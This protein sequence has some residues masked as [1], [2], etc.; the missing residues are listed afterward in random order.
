MRGREGD[1]PDTA[2]RAKMRDNTSETGDRGAAVGGGDLKPDNAT[3]C[4]LSDGTSRPMAD[5]LR[6][7]RRDGRGA[8]GLHVLVADRA[9][10]DRDRA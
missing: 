8:Q 9:R 10:G 4:L 2:K 6:E 5:V 7:R 1:R 3:Q